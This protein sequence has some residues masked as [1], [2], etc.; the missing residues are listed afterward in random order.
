MVGRITPSGVVL[1]GS[2]F[3]VINNNFVT[4]AH[5]TNN[6]DNN[7]VITFINTNVTSSYQDTSNKRIVY[8]PAKI[9]S[10]DPLRDIAIL[11]SVNF[12]SMPIPI[13]GSDYVNIGDNLYITGYPHCDVGRMV[14]TYQTTV[15]GA[16]IL[17]DNSSLKVKHLVLNIQ[18]RPGQSGSP[19]YK[20]GTGELVAM[21]IG[22]FHPETNM[23]ANFG[24]V[25][26]YTLHQTTHA[27]SSEYIINML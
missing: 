22:A 8:Y 3:K 14:L 15:V 18:T 10:I 20:S 1:L 13:T 16:K 2:C 26:V 12:K 6:D 23:V 9:K 4:A 25:D 7:L 21:I 24:N 11:D 19:V 17:I 27:V 5:V